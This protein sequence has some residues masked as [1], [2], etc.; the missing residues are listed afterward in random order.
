MRD[1]IL[2]IGL[3][4]ASWPVLTN[5]MARNLLP[6]LQNFVIKGVSGPLQSLPVTASPIVWT[7]IASGKTPEKHGVTEFIVTSKAVKTKRIWDIVED[8][9]MSVGMY[10]WLVTYPVKKVNGFMVPCW[11]TTSPQAHPDELAFIKTME[12]A[13][14]GKHKVSLG[15]LLSAFFAALKWQVPVMT[16]FSLCGKMIKKIVLRQLSETDY[17]RTRDL[18]LSLHMHLFEKIFQ[19]FRPEFSAV[20]LT[21]IDNICHRY[22]KYFEPEKYHDIPRTDVNK[23]ANVIPAMYQRADDFIGRIL[24]DVDEDTT[25]IVLSDHGFQALTTP[26]RLDP[27]VVLAGTPFQNRFRFWYIGAE[28]FLKALDGSAQTRQELLVFLRDAKPI[29]HALP[30]F[31]VKEKGALIS[32]RMTMEVFDIMDWLKCPCQLGDRQQPI[33]NLMAP[34]GLFMCGQHAPEGIFLA[35]GKNINRGKTLTNASVLDVTP[36]ILRLL[37]MP[38]GND[39][40]GKVLNEAITAE[41]LAKHPLKAIDT[42]GFEGTADGS[43]DQEAQQKIA[44]QLKKLGYL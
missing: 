16:L 14:K 10:G 36:T 38:V 11:L 28:V 26:Q 6:N 7:T 42:Y 30:L 32:L 40:D 34:D 37:D 9:G 8:F 25:V 29:G 1:K 17:W 27:Q 41:F 20:V 5:L 15:Q 44:E 24:Q 4:G 33:A 22:W 19:R 39:M 2:I 12:L 43:M 13:Y 31:E 21:E 18:T 3:D 35:V 23:F